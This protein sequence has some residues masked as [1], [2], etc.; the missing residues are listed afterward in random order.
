MAAVR[1]TYTIDNLPEGFR[2][3]ATQNSIYTPVFRE[4]CRLNPDNSVSCPPLVYETVDAFVRMQSVV[5]EI[6]KREQL[7]EVKPEPLKLLDSRFVHIKCL[8]CTIHK[9]KMILFLLFIAT[10]LIT[11]TSTPILYYTWPNG[12]LV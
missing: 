11:C 5:Y 3:D 10:L 2:Y 12:V 9:H 6:Q 1:T 8:E 4:F 7:A